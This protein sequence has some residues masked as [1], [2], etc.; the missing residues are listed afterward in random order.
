M[1]QNY[2]LMICKQVLFYSHTVS[3]IPIQS[4]K[5]YINCT[6]HKNVKY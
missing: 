3:K 2:K 1:K 4:I 5:L 6:E